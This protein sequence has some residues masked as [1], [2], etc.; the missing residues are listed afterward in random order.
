MEQSTYAKN[1]LV[2]QIKAF[3]GSKVDEEAQKMD[4]TLED[5][6]RVAKFSVSNPVKI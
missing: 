3:G 4:E 2:D 1:E 5:Y 6:P